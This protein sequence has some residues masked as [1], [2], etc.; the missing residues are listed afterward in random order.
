MQSLQLKVM[1]LVSTFLSPSSLIFFATPCIHIDIDFINRLRLNTIQNS[2]IFLPVPFY[3]YNSQF[4]NLMNKDEDNDQINK[5]TGYFNVDSFEFISFYNSDFIITLLN[6][7]VNTTQLNDLYDLFGLNSNLRILR[8]PDQ[9]FKCQWDIKHQQQQQHQCSM[10]LNEDEESCQRQHSKSLG[11]KA[12]L[13]QFIINNF[14]S[15]NKT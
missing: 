12:Q 11:N 1:K 13:A 9:S 10:L 3:K 8:A 2:Q 4:L 14:K 15:L 6:N 7:D 5:N